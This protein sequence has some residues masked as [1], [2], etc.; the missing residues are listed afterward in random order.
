MPSMPYLVINNTGETPVEARELDTI[1]DQALIKHPKIEIDVDK[2]EVFDTGI[3]F[4]EFQG[5]FQADEVLHVVGE[6]LEGIRLRGFQLWLH[7][8]VGTE[9][10][11]EHLILTLRSERLRVFLE[12]TLPPLVQVKPYFGNQPTPE[13]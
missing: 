3:G 12:E 6:Q 7:C 2:S 5:V 1:L 13:A 8:S 10:E 11:L 4:R 9:E